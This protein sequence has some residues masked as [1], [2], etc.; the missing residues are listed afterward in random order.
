[1]CFACPAPSCRGSAGDVAFD[2]LS[3]AA[4]VHVAPASAVVLAGV[5]WGRALAA[6][7]GT[8]VVGNALLAVHPLPVAVA[9]AA[10]LCG[11]GLGV[12]SVAATDMGMTVPESTK[13]TAAGAL[14]TAAQLGAAIGTAV[15]LLVAT[16]LHPQTA[17]AAL[18]AITALAAAHRAPRRAA[19]APAL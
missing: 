2:L 6:G 13:A 8:I 10:G 1:M 18:A 11:L 3:A 5:G 9:F 7:F 16:A 19:R 14:N 15:I 17:S 12:A 4:V